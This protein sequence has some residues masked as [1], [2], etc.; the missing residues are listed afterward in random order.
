M[1][2]ITCPVCGKEFSDRATACPQCGY[3]LEKKEE[4]VLTTC[5]ECGNE[6][7]S[8]LDV[9][10][11][12]GCP[13]TETKAE[14][15]LQKV[16]VTKVAVNKKKVIK[17]TV[18]AVAIVL[19]VVICFVVK[20]NSDVKD[21]YSNLDDATM[22]MLSGCADAET[23]AGLIHDV[24]RN[25]IYEDRDDETD[26]YTCPDGFFVSD[27]NEALSNLWLDSS[28]LTDIDEIKKNQEDVQKIMKDLK[29]PPDKYSEAY[30]DLKEF[31]DVY[32]EFTNL[33]INPSGNLTSYTQDYNE[34]DSEA[35]SQYDKMKVHLD[36]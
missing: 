36:E 15:K 16:E 11:N 10:P 28:F 18:I 2:M 13:K 3:V 35:M 19:V 4:I 25:A 26:K 5:E 22:L 20:K 33:A 27:F 6:F 29:N 7:D 1:A 32:L 21:Y 34:L 30:S 17:G 9:C 23:S 12:C 14:E 31:Y 24:W 8:K